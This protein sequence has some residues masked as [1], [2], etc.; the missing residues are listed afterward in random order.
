M[1]DDAPRMGD[2]RF[3]EYIKKKGKEEA[4]KDY[5]DDKLNSMRDMED[6]ISLYDGNQVSRMMKIFKEADEK[7]D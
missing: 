5:I 1:Y 3:L 6:G 4:K 2:P 7:Y